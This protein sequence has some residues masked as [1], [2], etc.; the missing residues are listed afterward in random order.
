MQALKDIGALLRQTREERG[1]SLEQLQSETKI[2]LRYL[3]AL[4][5]GDESIIPGEVYVKGFLRFYANQLGLDGH[6]L[7]EEYKEWREAQQ[8]AA[9]AAAAAAKSGHPER[10]V[11]PVTA[12]APAR[13]IVAAAPMTSGGGRVGPAQPKRV[14]TI[15]IVAIIAVALVVGGAW[16]LSHRTSPVGGNTPAPGTSDP[17][18]PNNPGGTTNPPAAQFTVTK[19]DLGKGG[20]RYVT[21]APSIKV[22]VDVMQKCWVKVT[23]DGVVIVDG[24]DLT[25]G[26]KMTWEAK[27]KLVVKY[28]NVGGV[29]FSVSGIQQE[30]AGADG[31]VRTV[32]Y[33]RK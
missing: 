10:P 1:L 22:D 18:V 21:T 15:A 32:S 7:V 11:K 2:R 17:T 16:A 30:V 12:Q 3:E 8:V 4:E 5:A 13:P 14:A 25:P 29:T 23:A 6:A 31:A 20:L 33:E 24:Q 19:E 28:G 26:M 27:D 9:E